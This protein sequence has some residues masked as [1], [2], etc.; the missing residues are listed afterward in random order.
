MKANGIPMRMPIPSKNINKPNVSFN[1]L[2]P[3]KSTRASERKEKYAPID[4][5]NMADW[6]ANVSKL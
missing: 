6:I 4:E 1:F 3:N 2:K 5:P